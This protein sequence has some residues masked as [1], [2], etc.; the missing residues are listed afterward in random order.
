RRIRVRPVAA[1]LA[2][3]AA[4]T[5]ARIRR[6]VASGTGLAIPR[7]QSGDELWPFA[8]T[9]SRRAADGEQTAE[10]RILAEDGIADLP[11][12]HRVRRQPR[13]Y[14][15]TQHCRS[16]RQEDARSFAHIDL[17]TLGS[18]EQDVSPDAEGPDFPS[19]IEGSLRC[20]TAATPACIGR[21]G[22]L[23]PRSGYS[24]SSSLAHTCT[25]TS[26]AV[27]RQEPRR[28]EIARIMARGRHPANNHVLRDGQS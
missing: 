21:Q 4:R 26:G 5:H 13:P 20:R 2:T 23:S 9:L 27:A 16:D 12:D 11:A 18:L 22:A 1:H 19:E 15:G 7:V 24:L 6:D 28:H 14:C 3:G 17:P 10:I 25:T 8:A